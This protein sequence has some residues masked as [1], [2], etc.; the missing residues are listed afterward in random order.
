MASIALM[1]CAGAVA[2]IAC[3]LPA[4]AEEARGTA[5]LAK[6][7]PHGIHE[8]DTGGAGRTGPTVAPD[9]RILLADPAI[10]NFRELSEN[11]YDFSD[12]NSNIPGFG[13]L[14]P[15]EDQRSLVR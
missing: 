12:P 15:S 14:L 8:P 6:L 4:G 3:I 13:P 11:D 10:R 7:P 1:Q 2:L 5:E 9:I